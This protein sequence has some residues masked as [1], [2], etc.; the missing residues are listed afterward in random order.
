M[1]ERYNELYKDM[2][3]SKDVEKMHVF[4]AVGKWMFCQL[5]EMNPRAAQMALD[6]LEALN[7]NNYLSAKE[8]EEIVSLLVNQ[9]G[10]KGPKWTFSQ[11]ENLI[12][13]IDENDE[14]PPYFNKYALWAVMNMLYSDH[15]KTAIKFVE[16]TELPKYFFELAVEKLKDPDRP[17]FVR[18]YFGV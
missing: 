3:T 13:D 2:A 5:A 14:C 4:G 17:R 15:A 12:E 16:E 7:W 9:N 6:K 11:F 10:T 18:M 8:A 1:I